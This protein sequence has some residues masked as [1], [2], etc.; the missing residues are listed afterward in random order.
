MMTTIAGKLDAEDLALYRGLSA[1]R[2]A[3]QRHP[4]AYSAA[5][6]EQIEMQWYRFFGAATEKYGLDDSR[7]IGVSP[8]A[9]TIIYGEWE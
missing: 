4:E 9:G 7:A 1:R 3:A 2:Q 6:H 8:H 5:E